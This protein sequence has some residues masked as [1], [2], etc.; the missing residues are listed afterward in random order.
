MTSC[1]FSNLMGLEV[2][3]GS[4]TLNFEYREIT[5]S[6]LLESSEFP[7]RHLDPTCR[8]RAASLMIS[9]RRQSTYM[10]SGTTTP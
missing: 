8:S 5:L 2:P 9:E 7:P 3:D 1:L 10:M 6:Q 4:H